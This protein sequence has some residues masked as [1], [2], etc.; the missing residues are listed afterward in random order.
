MAQL[1]K[2]ESPEENALFRRP[3]GVLK[4][5]EQWMFLKKRYH[6]TSRETQVAILICRGFT[7]EEISE[8]LRISES[9]VKTH[10]KNLYRR[11]RVDSRILLL[12]QF[13]EDINKA[14]GK[15]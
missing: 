1:N 14:Y 7:N 6:L 4:D 2:R 12:L 5:D 10:L 11:V 13:V 15:T 3:E 8:A 9:T